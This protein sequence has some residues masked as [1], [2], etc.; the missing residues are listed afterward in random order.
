[1]FKIRYSEFKNRIKYDL[2]I[3]KNGTIEKIIPND[4]VFHLKKGE[5]TLLEIPLTK[6][7]GSVCDNLSISN[8][9][10]ERDLT[11]SCFTFFHYCFKTKKYYRII[12]ENKKEKNI[13]KRIL[14]STEK[15]RWWKVKI[16]EVDTTGVF[17]RSCQNITKGS[18]ISLE[19][20]IL[21]ESTASEIREKI[22]DFVKE[23]KYQ[24]IVLKKQNMVLCDR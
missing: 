17:K 2:K 20:E 9:N 6:K 16:D 1:V 19:I 11:D 21:L 4:R 23:Y 10:S 7:N 5:E 24:K 3:K 15:N 12:I 8:Y 13:F 14:N 18:Q 22:V